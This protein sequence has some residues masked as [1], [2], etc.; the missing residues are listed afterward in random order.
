[1]KRNTIIRTCLYCWLRG[2]VFYLLFTLP[3]LF[4]P[5]MYA[6][7]AVLAAMGSG[8]PLLMLFLLLAYY[9]HKD[10]HADTGNIR[11]TVLLFTCIATLLG[12]FCAAYLITEGRNLVT[13]YL[14]FIL[15]PIAA[16]IAAAV[17]IWSY[18]DIITDTVNT[19]S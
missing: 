5:L 1:M 18:R 10:Q 7:S 8:I 15:F 2:M 4:I 17:A 16:I 19:G 6:I 9:K 3:A 13:T 12:T 11:I 14:D